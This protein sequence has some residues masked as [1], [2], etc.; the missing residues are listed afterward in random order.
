[1][2]PVN[3]PSLVATF[4]KRLVNPREDALS[5]KGNIG[6]W[7]GWETKEVWEAVEAMMSMWNCANQKGI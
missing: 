7:D 6:V 2:S 3:D 5:I 1:V 4:L